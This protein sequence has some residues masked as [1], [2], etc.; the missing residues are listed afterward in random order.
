MRLILASSSPR[1]R[2]IL[3]LLG[4]PFEVIAPPFEEI[5]ARHRSV[6][7]EVLEFAVEKA[8]SVAAKLPQCIV[9]G[10]DTMIGLDGEKFGKPASVDDAGRMLRAFSGKV[11]RIYTSVAI[12]DGC[13]GPGLGIVERVTVKMRAFSEYEVDSYLACGESL[14]KAGAYSIQG[15]GSR[16]I[17]FVEGDYLAAVG[18]PL[19]PIARYLQDRGISIPPDV[20]KFF[21]EKAFQN[22]RSA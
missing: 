19:R 22:W 17:E 13:G 4:V 14:D 5:I 12:V 18:M 15:E 6:E 21:A 16:L 9:I 8:A 20:E 11:H 1:R 10:S 2:E 7:E 3:A